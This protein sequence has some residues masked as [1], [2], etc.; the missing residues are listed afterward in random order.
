MEKLRP[1][2]ITRE[3]EALA[4]FPAI[5]QELLQHLDDEDSNLHHLADQ[6]RHDPL[7]A[8]RLL[9]LANAA[10]TANRNKTEVRDLYTAISLIGLS[11]FRQ[12][13]LSLSIAGGLQKLVPSHDFEQ[14]WAHSLE[15]AVAAQV[16]AEHCKQP[17]EQAYLCGLMHDLGKLWLLHHAQRPQPA[18]NTPNL[19]LN[20]DFLRRQSPGM[21]D[22]ALEKLLLGM[23]HA[24][25]GYLLAKAWKLPEVIC[26]SIHDHHGQHGSLEPVA[27]VVQ[28]AEA[29]VFVLNASRPGQAPV[30]S[31]YSLT[32]LNPA[33]ETVLKPDWEQM[34]FILGEIEARARALKGEIAHLGPKPDSAT[35]A[36]QSGETA[37]EKA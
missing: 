15:V 1:D 32:R 2:T 24:E 36:G 26:Q 30:E 18:S 20:N 4:V 13:V 5:V 37:A 23:D 17:A 8:A 22:E 12:L 34:P 33:I 28:L 10:S 31:G 11:R 27:L 7:I 25:I 29:V 6:A 16:L 3:A 19:N 21:E 9:A 14:Y 35:P